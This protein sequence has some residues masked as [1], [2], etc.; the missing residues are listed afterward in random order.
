MPGKALLVAP[1]SQPREKR[2]NDCNR[3]KNR[4]EPFLVLQEF[5]AG[6]SQATQWPCDRFDFTGNHCERRGL[7]VQFEAGIEVGPHWQVGERFVTWHVSDLRI[8]TAKHPEQIVTHEIQSAGQVSEV[9]G[10]RRPP[11]G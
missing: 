5:V 6:K 10:P 11:N 1:D 9:T 8:Q 4:L 2:C 7:Q 3:V